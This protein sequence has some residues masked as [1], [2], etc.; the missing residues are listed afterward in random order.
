MSVGRTVLS[1][2]GLADPAGWPPGLL[3]PADRERFARYAEALCF[4]EGAQWLGRPRRGRR[5]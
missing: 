4:Y 3:T 5:G 2:G 1:G